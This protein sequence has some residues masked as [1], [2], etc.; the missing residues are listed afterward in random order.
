MFKD[1]NYL[2]PSN[3]DYIEGETIKDHAFNVQEILNRIG[4]KQPF[5]IIVL[6]DCCRDYHLRHRDLRNVGRG[7]TNTDVE[8][9]K[10]FKV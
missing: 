8:I 10:G 1:Q 9:S 5:V 2:I 4:Q 6:L 3:D 7:L